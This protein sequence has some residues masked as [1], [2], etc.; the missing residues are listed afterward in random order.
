[1]NKINEYE[2]TDDQIVILKNFR[3]YMEDY[4]ELD[5]DIAEMIEEK[6]WDMI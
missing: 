5:T 1:M 6:F 2:L 4:V 3:D